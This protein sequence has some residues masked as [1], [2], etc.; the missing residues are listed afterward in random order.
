MI[1]KRLT[2]NMNSLDAKL[3]LKGLKA[4]RVLGRTLVVRPQ[5][6]A[7]WKSWYWGRF[8]VLGGV[9]KK[10]MELYRD[11]FESVIQDWDTLTYE[12][13]WRDPEIA[14]FVSREISRG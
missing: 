5:R 11:H 13:L 1:S 4:I 14:F 8:L 9:W 2:E 7:P 12:D 6:R 10:P 3:K